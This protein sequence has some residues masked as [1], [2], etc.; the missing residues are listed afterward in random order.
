MS[1]SVAAQ[2]WP[3]PC[4]SASEA[5]LSHWPVLIESYVNGWVSMLREYGRGRMPAA[6]R[7]AWKSAY[8]PMPR[9]PCGSSRRGSS[10]SVVPR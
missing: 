2:P 3:R 10:S 4:G 7:L 8:G 9:G 5:P 6:L 1:H